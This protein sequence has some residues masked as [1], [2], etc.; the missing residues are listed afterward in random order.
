MNSN[1]GLSL[2]DGKN[3]Q[4]PELIVNKVTTTVRTMTEADV[5]VVAHLTAEV[6]ADPGCHRHD[7]AAA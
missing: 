4:A 7:V 1:N 3:P 2:L 5:D 6:F